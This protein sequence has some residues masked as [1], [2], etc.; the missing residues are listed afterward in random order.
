MRFETRNII[1]SLGVG[2][3]LPFTVGRANLGASALSPSFGARFLGLYILY[4]ARYT[5]SMRVCSVQAKSL[6]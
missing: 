5:Y 3:N 4:V 1:E 6:V 2:G